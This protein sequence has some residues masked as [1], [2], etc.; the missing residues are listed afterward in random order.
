MLISYLLFAFYAMYESLNCAL[1]ICAMLDHR[2]SHHYG[3]TSG[4]RDDYS[5][6]NRGQRYDRGRYDD[7]HSRGDQHYYDNDNYYDSRGGYGGSSRRGR[8]GNYYD[9]GQQGGGDQRSRYKYTADVQQT[10]PNTYD[11]RNDGPSA[12]QQPQAINDVL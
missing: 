9:S 1:N 12:S 3:Q 4:Y 10:Q 11:T 6:Q 5:Y 7:Y 8:G 2:G